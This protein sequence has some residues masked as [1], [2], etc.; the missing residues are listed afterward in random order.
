MRLWEKIKNCETHG[1]IVRVGRSVRFF[2]TGLPKLMSLVTFGFNTPFLCCYFWVWSLITLISGIK[3]ELSN[4]IM[5][6]GGLLLSDPLSCELYGNLWFKT[7]QPI[8]AYNSTSERFS[9]TNN[10]INNNNLFQNSSEPIRV[11]LLSRG[12]KFRKILNEEEVGN[13]LALLLYFGTYMI[14]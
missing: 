1:R 9:T 12:T 4:F 11:T 7:P 8:F 2:Y 13:F 5:T 6:F 3:Y 14:V 10:N